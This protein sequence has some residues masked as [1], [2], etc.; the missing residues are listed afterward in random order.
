MG[1]KMESVKLGALL[2]ITPDLEAGGREAAKM[3][4]AILKGADPGKIPV[5]PPAKFQLGINLTT[6]LKLNIVVPPD[7]LGLAGNHVYR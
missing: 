7:I 5:K 6:A 4:D 3:V 1:Q 2:H